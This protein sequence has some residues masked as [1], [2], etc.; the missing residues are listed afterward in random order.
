MGFSDKTDTVY[1]YGTWFWNINLNTTLNSFPLLVIFIFILNYFLW[2][3]ARVN[4]EKIGVHARKIKVTWQSIQPA[5]QL[6]NGNQQ[7][8]F[9]I[10]PLHPCSRLFNQHSGHQPIQLLMHN[11]FYDRIFRRVLYVALAHF[12]WNT[13]ISESRFKAP[14]MWRCVFYFLKGVKSLQWMHTKSWVLS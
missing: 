2:I 9:P 12:C 8:N 11:W 10:N 3:C 7:V 1:W 5:S 14:D 6:V 13:Q 4:W